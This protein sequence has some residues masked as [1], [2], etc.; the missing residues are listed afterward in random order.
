MTKKVVKNVGASVRERLLNLARSQKGDFQL[1]LTRYANERLLYRL[2]E[3]PHAGGFVLKGATLFAL[4]TTDEHR[5]TRDVD[6]LGFGEPTAARIH[7][8]FKDIL[9]RNVGDDGVEFD[10]MTLKVGPIRENQEY[11]GVRAVVVAR[12][13]AARVRLQ[14]DVG[15]GDS[16]VPE[17]VLVTLPTLLDFPSPKIRAYR[18]E[19]VVAE[20]LHAMV[21]LGL[22]NSR[23]KDFYDILLLS[24][25]FD[26]D[27]AP[28]VQAIRATF[29]RRGTA[30]PEGLPVGLTVAFTED[31]SKK[32]QWRAFLKK[33]YAADVGDLPTVAAEV[34]AFVA[35]PMQASRTAAR[36]A[37]RW[38]RGG[39]W[40]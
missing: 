18:R 23:M 15:F 17:P 3:S 11:G 35:V 5:A 20:K 29:D 21:E 39:R 16:I 37:Q 6:L 22:A 26:F 8:I 10:V 32:S 40:E 36:F 24:R 9:E 30:L 27:G 28:L 25:L 7:G 2:A 1:L 34:A 12:V 14:F 13:D 38:S 19:T 33:T 4:W 31:A